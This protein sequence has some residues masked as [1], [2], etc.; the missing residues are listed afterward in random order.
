M[1][2]FKKVVTN[3]LPQAVADMPQ[4]KKNKNSL[5]PLKQMVTSG[6]LKQRI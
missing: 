4:K 6:M 5:M 3:G 2:I 1:I